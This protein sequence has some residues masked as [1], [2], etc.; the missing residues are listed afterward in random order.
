MLGYWYFFD[1][2]PIEQ[3]QRQYTK[4]VI[5]FESVN[6]NEFHNNLMGI[7]YIDFFEKYPLDVYPLPTEQDFNHPTWSADYPQIYTQ[8][9]EMLTSLNNLVQAETA[10]A[11]FIA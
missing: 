5:Y 7:G 11:E 2:S 3:P 8:F 4:P 10:E 1:Q 6:W 9:L